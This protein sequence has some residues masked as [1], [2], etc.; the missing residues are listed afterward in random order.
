MVY[1][2]VLP[3]LDVLYPL[4][5]SVDVWSASYLVSYKNESLSS[6]SMYFHVKHF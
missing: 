6:H 5:S 4:I 3:T 2:I 1:E